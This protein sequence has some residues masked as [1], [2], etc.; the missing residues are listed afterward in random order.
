MTP[1][2]AS[3]RVMANVMR[4]AP[5]CS[6]RPALGSLRDGGPEAD[7]R[8]QGGSGRGRFRPCWTGSWRWA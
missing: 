2:A 8:K 4:L 5:E 3:I 6:V 1:Q 7:T